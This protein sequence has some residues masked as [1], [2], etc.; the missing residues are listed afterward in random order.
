IVLKYHERDIAAEG[1]IDPVIRRFDGIDPTDRPC[2]SYQRID[3]AVS[4]AGNFGD[5]AGSTPIFIL[6]T[7]LS[8]SETDLIGENGHGEGGKRKRGD[9]QPRSYP[10]PT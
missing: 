10:R 1:E 6:G 7:N 5:E 3:I 4:N 2:G 9:S 8:L